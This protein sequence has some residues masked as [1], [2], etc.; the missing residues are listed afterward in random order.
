MYQELEADYTVIGPAVD[1][2]DRTNLEKLV[3]IYH[4]D[5]QSS[6]GLACADKI[7]L[8]EKIDFKRKLAIECG[9]RPEDIGMI[10]TMLFSYL[11]Q[12]KEKY[13]LVSTLAEKQVDYDEMR[14]ELGLSGEE[15]HSIKH[16]LN[17]ETIESIS[18]RK[19]GAV[20]PL[21]EPEYLH[22]IEAVYF[23]HDLLKDAAKFPEKIYDVPRSF[24]VSEFWNAEAL[25]NSLRQKSAKYKTAGD[26]ETELEISELRKKELD[27][28]KAG[29]QFLF[30]GTIIKYRGQ[31][32]QITNPP[33]RKEEVPRHDRKR[34]QILCTAFPI[35]RTAEENITY[36]YTERG[37]KRLLLPLS[38]EI[39]AKSV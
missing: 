5:Y 28:A 13:L 23:T 39:L 37:R 19:R 35:A 38:Y 25:F 24:S 31:E 26:F 4:P 9:I 6:L 30:G 21:L 36:E 29:Y 10:K 32:Y 33:M 16:K 18:G 3:V 11:H 14:V 7:R 20:S 22:K 15:V 27:P 12:D 2:Q 8:W 34:K 17:D 1:L